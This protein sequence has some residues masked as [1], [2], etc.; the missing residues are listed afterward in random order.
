MRISVII[1]VYNEENTIAEILRRVDKVGVAYE[2]IVVDDGST[3]KT[4]EILSKIKTPKNLK[5]I[6][7]KKNKGKG[8]AIKTGLK[9]ISGE[10]VIIQ[11]AD[12][13]YNPKEYKKLMKP[14]IE[15]KSKVVYGT[16]IN[17]AKR[18]I[19]S[20]IW[21]Y[22]GGLTLSLLANSLYGLSITD[23]PTGYKVFEAEVLKSLKLENNG[24]D[25]CPEVTAKVAKAGYKIYEVPISYK[26]R[27]F[28]EGKKIRPKDG[29]I[30]IWTLLKYKFLAK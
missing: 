3:D 9:N 1:P 7:H 11:D 18:G 21:F 4:R 28:S 30:A 22:L 5:I 15:G 27:S 17:V 14:I 19:Y 13:E 26:P 16:R 25:F 8:A 10:I 29:F 23:E 2:V 20:N 12:L 24:F 6:F